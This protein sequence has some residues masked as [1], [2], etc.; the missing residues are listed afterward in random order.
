MS[1]QPPDI[2]ERLS[3]SNA[4]RSREH[5]AANWSSH[6]ITLFSNIRHFNHEVAYL[7]LS[8]NWQPLGGLFIAI[9]WIKVVSTAF[10]SVFEILGIIVTGI[11]QFITNCGQKWLAHNTVIIIPVKL[12]ALVTAKSIR[13]AKR[14]DR[15]LR[16]LKLLSASRNHLTPPAAHSRLKLKFLRAIYP[17][18]LQSQHAIPW[19]SVLEKGGQQDLN[20]LP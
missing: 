1:K 3:P 14:E 9:I 13:S 5:A 10:T 7:C 6:F 12:H 4:V 15:L 17:Y 11:K 20:Q 8:T 19:P 16:K 2:S 18:R